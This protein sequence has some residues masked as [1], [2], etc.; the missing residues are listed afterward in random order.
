MFSFAKMPSA[1]AL[2]SMTSI[3]LQENRSARRHEEGI[4]QGQTC[5]DCHKGIAHELP[6]GAFETDAALHG[7]GAASPG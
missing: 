3:T 1:A 6:E 5:I 2:Q 4:A 7:A